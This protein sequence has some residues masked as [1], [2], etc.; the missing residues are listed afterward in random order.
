MWKIELEGLEGKAVANTDV[1]THEPIKNVQARGTPFVTTTAGGKLVQETTK[2]V[3][4]RTIGQ[5]L[6]SLARTFGSLAAALL[7]PQTANA[8]GL[9]IPNV[10]RNS[11]GDIVPLN[12]DNAIDEKLRVDNIDIDN[13]T[14]NDSPVRRIGGLE[15]VLDDAEKVENSGRRIVKIKEFIKKGGFKEAL[16]D[17]ESL[18]LSN[19]KEIE[20][21][22][23]TGKVG[24]LS[25]GSTVSVRPGSS[26]GKATLQFNPAE[27]KSIKI[28]FEEDER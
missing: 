22:F 2:E 12:S 9:P 8:P 26:G 27:G 11:D 18:E 10:T 28:R 4:K 5:G 16:T 25:D 20:T 7:L 19:I 1:V 17:F 24:Q 21:K 14:D 15:T 23:G 13:V 3:V 6:G